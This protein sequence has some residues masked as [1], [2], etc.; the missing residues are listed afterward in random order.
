LTMSRAPQGGH[1]G[2]CG[3]YATRISGW[4]TKNEINYVN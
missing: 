2:R 3:P 1:Q 4:K